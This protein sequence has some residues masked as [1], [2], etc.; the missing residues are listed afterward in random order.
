MQWSFMDSVCLNN[1]VVSE[2]ALV[3]L[4]LHL[5]IYIQ[6][7]PFSNFLTTRGSPDPVL[8]V[9]LFVHCL[10]SHKVVVKKKLFDNINISNTINLCSR[11]AQIKTL[12]RT[13]Q[14]TFQDSFVS[15]K[16]DFINIF[17]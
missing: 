6:L 13:T 5:A 11:W 1:C 12:L 17:Y 15:Q 2:N 9:W 14:G 3:F 16:K 7:W 8:L 10:G 4:F